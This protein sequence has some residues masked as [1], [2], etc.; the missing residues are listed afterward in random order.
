M[1]L[2]T[3]IAA[4]LYMWS[5]SH[6]LRAPS[7]SSA[8]CFPNWSKTSVSPSQS[9]AKE[10]QPEMIYI[11][12]LSSTTFGQ[13]GLSCSSTLAHSQ[14]LFCFFFFLIS[15]SYLLR[16]GLPSFKVI[17]I[18][19][20]TKPGWYLWGLIRS[21]IPYSI[22]VFSVWFSRNLSSFTSPIPFYSL[23]NFPVVYILLTPVGEVFFSSY[24]SFETRPDDRPDLIIGSQVRW[25]NPG[26][27]KK[28][29][30]KTS[31][32]TI[33]LSYLSLSSICFPTF[34]PQIDILF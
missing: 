25:I 29:Q 4:F 9:N 2:K 15:I 31:I 5:L 10:N 26:Q 18:E 24:Y 22:F 14:Y 20:S 19:Y 28:N 17:S 1:N 27:P 8:P 6:I 3:W 23:E 32:N 12:T 7:N 21:Q 34:Q 13:P 16:F 33:P 11:C 30:I